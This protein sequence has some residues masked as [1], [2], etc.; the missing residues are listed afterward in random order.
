MT[1]GYAPKRAATTRLPGRADIFRDW[2][3]GAIQ[4]L[5]DRLPNIR[6]RNA[7]ES[8]EDYQKFRR[9]MEQLFEEQLEEL[10]MLQLQIDRTRARQQA[11]QLAMMARMALAERLRRNGEKNAAENRPHQLTLE[12]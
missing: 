9:R 6:A 2:K 5:S 3:H 1:L 8:Y 7:G 12:F 11:E 4:V 10:R